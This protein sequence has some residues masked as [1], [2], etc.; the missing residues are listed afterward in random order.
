MKISG[1]PPTSGVTDVLASPMMSLA[2]VEAKGLRAA[3]NG[4]SPF[5]GV[6]RSVAGALFGAAY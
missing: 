6:P 1:T 4:H 5:S 2:S 3:T